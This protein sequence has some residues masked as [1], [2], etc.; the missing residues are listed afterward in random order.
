VLQSMGL[1][2]VGHDLAT[3][4]THGIV[5]RLWALEGHNVLCWLFVDLRQVRVLPILS[6]LS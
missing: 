1:Q 4:H 6:F 5:I 2:R 3:E